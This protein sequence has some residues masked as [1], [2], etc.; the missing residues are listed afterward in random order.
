MSDSQSIEDLV[1]R[2]YRAVADLPDADGADGSIPDPGT[3]TRPRLR[4][5]GVF[6]TVA[7]LVAASV[8]VGVVLAGTRSAR[9]AKRAA[10]S[11]SKHHKTR[12]TTNPGVVTVPN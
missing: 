11:S 3:F 6:I 8:G 12:P 5:Q 10:P 9:V 1:R 4:R 2:T 7:V